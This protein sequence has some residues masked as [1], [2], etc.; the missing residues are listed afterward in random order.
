MDNTK[1]LI[2][3]HDGVGVGH[4]SKMANLA[5]LLY[6]YNKKNE[7]HFLSGYSKVNNFLIDDIS[8][9]KLPSY[10]KVLLQ[11]DFNKEIK[12]KTSKKIRKDIL[13]AIF[14]N[15]QFDYIIIDMFFWGT[16][17]ELK[18][19]LPK[20]KK[21][22]PETKIILTLRGVIFSVDQTKLFFKKSHGI[23]YINN[24][25]SK[26][27]CFCD[28]RIININKKYFD[29]KLTIPTKYLGYI[30][31]PINSTIQTKNGSTKNI[32]VNF[33]GSYKCDEILENLLKCLNDNKVPNINIY[34]VLGEY[35]QQTT[36]NNI[37]SF[38][39]N[40][41]ICK[42]LPKKELANIRFDL[43]IG[44]GGYNV[45]VDA[46]FNNIP[47][48]VVPKD[49][50]DEASIHAEILKKYS[51]IEMLPL[52]QMEKIW[53]IINKQLARL[54][55]HDLKSFTQAEIQELLN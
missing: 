37:Y 51:S 17:N 52:N 29:D 11:S 28:E 20:V 34:V 38:Y 18:E 7:I 13:K 41:H 27:V 49:R 2:Y 23:K 50:T 31:Y 26:V 40:F 54:T 5:H 21:K 55:K 12:D 16:R 24:N 32:I 53:D 8:Y 3:A 33:G 15:T 4:V 36:I 14:Y 43:I 48:V 35:L 1:M 45:M 46:I 42:M 44:C 39:S 22:Y 19:I 6:E 10:N 30:Y 25:F 47:F 9:I